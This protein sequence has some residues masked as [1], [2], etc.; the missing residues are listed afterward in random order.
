MAR[1]TEE[2]IHFF[3]KQGFAIVST[4][5]SDGSIHTACKGVLKIT[6]EGEIYL[7]DLYMGRTY[8]NLE[9]NGVISIASADEHTFSGFSLKGK[10]SIIP[11]DKLEPEILKAWDAMIVSRLTRRLL[12]NIREEK[13]HPA[14]PEALLP[15]PKYMI[16]AEVKEVI[17]L[18]P[19]HLK[20]SV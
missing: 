14:H 19:K 7:V 3:K 11:R 17:D 9:R 4:L 6:P 12:K 16:R 2:I 1:V 8:Q 15:S 13:G 10:A 18:T 5:N 20:Q